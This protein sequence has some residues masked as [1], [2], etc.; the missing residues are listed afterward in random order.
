MNFTKLLITLLYR[1]LLLIFSICKSEWYLVKKHV[2]LD[3]T[4]L[5]LDIQ[6]IF[7]STLNT[8]VILQVFFRSVHHYSRTS[9]YWLAV[10][11]REVAVKCA[12]IAANLFRENIINLK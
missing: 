5:L 9:R 11:R 4:S 6:A 7:I 12:F 10:V 2:R 3:V 1:L 8:F